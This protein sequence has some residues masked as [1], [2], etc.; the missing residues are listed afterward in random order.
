VSYVTSTSE[1]RDDDVI[2]VTEENIMPPGDT[3]ADETGMA[4]PG[5]YGS[6]AETDEAD[7]G[8]LASDG[9]DPGELTHDD[10]VR[11]RS[12]GRHEAFAMP[13]GE[14]VTD[15]TAAHDVAADDAATN[16]AVADDRLTDS[17]ITDSA[18]SDGT[19]TDETVTGETVADEPLTGEAATAD[20][21]A[22]PAAAADPVT[23]TDAPA[24]T[25]A[26]ATTDAAA[27]AATATGGTV[28]GTDAGGDPWP[29]IQ[30]RFVDDPRSAVE[31]AAEV[32]TGALTALMASARNRE[33]SLRDGWQADATGTED[34]RTALRDYRELAQRLSG[35]A[36]QL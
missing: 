34:L 31:Q 12:A 15:E 29:E 9:R 20:E 6:A 33:Q 14:S 10:D 5:S 1:Q 18:V 3:R 23:T 36:G 16:D 28:A 30:A 32:T 21:T 22:A 11:D 35:L 13:G 7:T 4:E 19:V 24:A 27:P 17:A 2:I 26:P 25:E 8:E